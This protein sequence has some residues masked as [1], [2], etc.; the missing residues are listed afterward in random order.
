M[1]CSKVGE[2]RMIYGLEDESTQRHV[3]NSGLLINT[4]NP[5]FMGVVVIAQSVYSLFTVM[6]GL[7]RCG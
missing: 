7:K 5:F 3:V 4:I 1:L 2:W 6:V